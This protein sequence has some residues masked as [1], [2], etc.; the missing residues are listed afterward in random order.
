[1]GVAVG[2]YSYDDS[3]LDIESILDS[4]TCVGRTQGIGQIFAF[5][6]PPPPPQPLLL[7]DVSMMDDHA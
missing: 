3:L 5:L 7:F 2:K 4:G 1:M 6:S